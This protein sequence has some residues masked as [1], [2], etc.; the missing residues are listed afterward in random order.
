M[1]YLRSTLP[2][3]RDPVWLLFIPPL[4]GRAWLLYRLHAVSSPIS[5]TITLLLMLLLAV[6]G[7]CGAALL[8]RH[9]YLS[10]RPR[11]RF[12]VMTTLGTLAAPLPLILMESAGWNLQ[13]SWIT[14][15]L[16]NTSMPLPFT[17]AHTWVL[18][19]PTLALLLILW[20]WLARV[21]NPTHPLFSYPRKLATL[22][23]AWSSATLLL[24]L[25]LRLAHAPSVLTHGALALATLA[26]PIFPAALFILPYILIEWDEKRGQA[27]T[28][29]IRVTL[30]VVMLTVI[31]LY[32]LSQLY[33]YVSETFSG[34]MPS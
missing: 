25:I 31:A 9:A 12:L 20:S 2:P 28:P 34:G 14:L 13:F 22:P 17:L 5:V 23:L 1:H 18:V 16:P 3:L 21:F 4:I 7:W 33:I 26:L 19:V 8:A 24:A 10:E 30:H 29:R 11:E 32:F 27:F 15:L 6:L